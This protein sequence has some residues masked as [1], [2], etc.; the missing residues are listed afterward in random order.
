MGAGRVFDQGAKLVGDAIESG[1]IWD[2][3]AWG[4]ATAGRTLHLLGLVS[5]GN[6]HSHI[7]HLRALIQRAATEGVPRIRIHV[8][9]DGRDVDARSALTWVRPLEQEL[10]ALPV[11]AA[12]A[13]GGGRMHLTMDRYEADWDMVARGWSLHVHGNGRRFP[14]A[15]AAIESLY[16]ADPDVDDQYLP[17]FVV[18]DY[19]GMDDGDA[20]IF[21]NFRG[22]RAM[23]ISRAFDTG[24][25]FD[26]F[27]RGRKPDV[28]YA[29]MMEYDGDTKTPRHSLV[30]PPAID[31]TVSQYFEAA[32][33]NV[34]SVSETQKYGHVT[35]F[36]N[37]NRSEPGKLEKWVEVPSRQSD[38]A[39][40]PAMLAQEVT[41]Y[42][43]D[44]IPEGGYPHIRL[45][46][47]NG[48]MVG[49]TGDLEATA[50]AVAVLDDC[51]GQLIAACEAHGVVMVLTADHGNADEM[52]RVDKKTGA[53]A[54]DE[55]GARVV[56]PSHSCNPVP[57]AIVDPTGRWTLIG[58][59]VD[60]V[61]GGIAQIG[62]T[63]LQ[64]HDLPVPDNYLPSLVRPA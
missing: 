57:V 61:V 56:S 6:V 50:A 26:A 5:D 49:H 46:L 16:A 1:R 44:E 64:L 19:T 52:F 3:P 24:D 15:S 37:G 18:G 21:F 40:E 13:T 20:V 17:G 14:S 39:A 45:N 53:Y 62:A 25:E 10:A 55:T 32:K 35:Y 59:H 9:T 60:E 29:G 22:D 42:V 27:D 28:F 47:A 41:K 48:D 7:D 11:D 63:L 12:V 31:G 38:F 54:Q 8:L 30:A 51:V 4:R 23:E 43:I 58:N 34:L 2:S 33:L 36:F